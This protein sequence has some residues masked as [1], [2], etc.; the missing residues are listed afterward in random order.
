ML[1]SYFK[2]KGL[3]L[4]Q[5]TV[6]AQNF[7][8]TAT[9]TAVVCPVG[10]HQHCTGTQCRAVASTLATLAM[11]GLIFARQIATAFEEASAGIISTHVRAPCVLAAATIRLVLSEVPFYCC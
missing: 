6:N 5:S 8:A 7:V 2:F 4:L 10:E 3:L 11:A 1:L 9:M